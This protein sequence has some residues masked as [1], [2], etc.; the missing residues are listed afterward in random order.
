M[1]NLLK[2][3]PQLGVASSLLTV[4]IT[5]LQVLQIIGAILGIIIAVI[6]AI[7]KVLELRDRL[8]EKKALKKTHQHKRRSAGHLDHLNS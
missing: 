4:A 3:K 2:A 7:L 1:I 5:H 8:N 6:T